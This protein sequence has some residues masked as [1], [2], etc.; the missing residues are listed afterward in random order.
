MSLSMSG[1]IPEQC[2]GARAM[3]RMKREELAAAAQVAPATLFDFESGRRQPQPRT[4]AAIRAA[5]EAAG[6]V[7]TNGDEPGVKLRKQDQ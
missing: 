5:L 7:F 4:L 1:I 3:L 6:V 2:L